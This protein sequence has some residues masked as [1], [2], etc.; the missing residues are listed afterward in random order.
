MFV[1]LFTKSHHWSLLGS[2]LSLFG[3][4]ITSYYFETYMFMVSVFPSLYA[5]SFLVSH[6]KFCKF[7]LSRDSLDDHLPILPLF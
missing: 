6:A 5:F 7:L 4:P 2:N 1:A 3:L